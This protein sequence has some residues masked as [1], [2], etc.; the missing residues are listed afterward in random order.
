MNVFVAI[1]FSHDDRFGVIS[2]DRIVQ[3]NLQLVVA[4]IAEIGLQ[5]LI[6]EPPDVVLV[7]ID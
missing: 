5:I 1:T 6:S 3:E 2:L 4:S 7:P